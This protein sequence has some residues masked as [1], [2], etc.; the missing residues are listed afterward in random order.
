[1]YG[2]TT[3]YLREGQQFCDVVVR[4]CFSS[5]RQAGLVPVVTV[6]SWITIGTLVYHFVTGFYWSQAFFFAIDAGFSIGF[7]IFQEGTWSDVNI[8]IPYNACAASGAS[9]LK[10]LS[11]QSLACVSQH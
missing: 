3:T 4:V 6:L 1:M 8:T 10:L 9:V 2:S 5:T 7:G 11:V